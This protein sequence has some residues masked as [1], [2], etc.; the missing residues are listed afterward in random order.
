M[1]AG[2]AKLCAV[3]V[4]KSVIWNVYVVLK[5]IPHQIYVRNNQQ[6]LI[7]NRY[8]RPIRTIRI[9]HH[10]SAD[11]ID[12]PSSQSDA[13]GMFQLSEQSH[14]PILLQVLVNDIPIQMEMDTGASVSIISEPSSM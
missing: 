4:I 7:V 13:Y 5:P 8:I 2:F 3:S 14:D 10:I 1:S 9:D 11:D 6:H 12:E